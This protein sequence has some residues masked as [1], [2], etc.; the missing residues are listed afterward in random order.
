MGPMVG[1][2]SVPTLPLYID[3]FKYLST[4]LFVYVC[5]QFLF[6]FGPYPAVL[7]DYTW[8]Y[9]SGMYF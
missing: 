3:I 6:C 1:I 4:Y 2:K 9:I 7:R 8:L 5:V